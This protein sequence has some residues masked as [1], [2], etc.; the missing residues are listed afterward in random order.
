MY[1]ISRL[2][3]HYIKYCL[4][5]IHTYDNNASMAVNIAEMITIRLTNSTINYISRVYHFVLKLS[6]K[7][8]I[9]AVTFS[10]S[11]NFTT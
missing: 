8:H 7:F 4:I 6:W 10:S 3:V 11:F 9:S 2:M 5:L 1:I